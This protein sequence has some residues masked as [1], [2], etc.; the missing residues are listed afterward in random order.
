MGK[1][2]TRKILGIPEIHFIHPT[3][4]RKIRWI[5][6]QNYYYFLIPTKNGGDVVRKLDAWAT[7][8]QTNMSVDC[9]EY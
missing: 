4:C 9:F 5:Q 2:Q 6:W 7:L 8:G 1:P 3:R